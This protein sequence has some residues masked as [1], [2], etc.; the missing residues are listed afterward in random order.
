MLREA[1]MLSGI[2]DDDTKE[3]F[4]H[5]NFPSYSVG[6][7]RPNRAPGR[8][9]IGHGALA[10]RALLS[11]I[12]PIEEFPYTIRLVSEVISSNGSTS[13]GAVCGSTLALMDAGVPI[14]APVAGISCGLVCYDG[15]HITMLDIQGIEDFFG[16]MDFKVA[17][18]KDG[19]TAIQVDIKNDGLTY[20]I[21]EEAFEKT[22][23]ARLKIIDEVI[24]PVIPVPRVN[25]NEFVPKIKSIKISVDKIRE[26]IGPGGKVVQKL[27]ADFGVTIDIQ[28]NGSVFVASVNEEDTQRA[29]EQIE[30]IVQEPEVGK[31]YKGKVV[32]LMPFGAFVE[33]FPGKEGLVHISRFENRR[34]ERIEDVAKFGDEI[35]VKL[36][37]IDDQ[38]KL[39][40]SKKDAVGKI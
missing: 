28:E 20:E 9:E 11:V 23:A 1:Q 10:E 40:L 26:V 39:V 35:L 15:G 5:Y 13:Q 18:T 4:H 6:E 17:G 8:R 24:L 34:V 38:G 21:I 36:I 31:T 14:K 12:P 16:D 30:S 37:S 2:E 27:C 22:R 3:Y 32:K 25:L 29:I 19:I 7:T 33:I